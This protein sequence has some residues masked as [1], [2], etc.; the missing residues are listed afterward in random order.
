MER[1]HF[2]QNDSRESEGESSHFF[3]SLITSRLSLVS[4]SPSL[5]A[6]SFS[7]GREERERK[8]DME[9]GEREREREGERG[10]FSL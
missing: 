10:F 5:S 3:L 8:K 2:H 6:L 1:R 7:V 4:L 9:E